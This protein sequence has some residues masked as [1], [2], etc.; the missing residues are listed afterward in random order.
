MIVIVEESLLKK[1]REG[2]LQAQ[3]F[4]STVVVSQ[5][6]KLETLPEMIVGVW[7][8]DNS[9]QLECTTEFRKL[10]SIECNP[11][12]EEVIQSGSSSLR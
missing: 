10:L 2:L 12:I 4:P 6:D 1:R 11:P 9:M 3:Q 8:D 7:S 5:L